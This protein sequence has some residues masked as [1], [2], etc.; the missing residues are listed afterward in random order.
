MSR[1][2][3]IKFCTFLLEDG[4]W[5]LASDEDLHEELVDE[6]LEKQPAPVPKTS[7]ALPPGVKPKSNGS[8][9]WA[10]FH[11]E[12]TDVLSDIEEL[13]DKCSARDGWY[14]QVYGMQ[15]WADEHKHVTDNMKDALESIA[16]G[17]AKWFR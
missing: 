1:A 5:Q 11:D 2:L 7:K 4:N 13:P 6:F 17:V 8:E 14:E 10:V 16:N 12:C 9:A 15:T 3:L